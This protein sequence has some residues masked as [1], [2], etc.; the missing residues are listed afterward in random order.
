MRLVHRDRHLRLRL[1][2]RA[3]RSTPCTGSSHSSSP[4]GA[5]A[6]RF[7]SASSGVLPGAVGVDADADLR[8]DRGAHGGQ[9]A[10]VVADPDLDLHAAEPVARG[11][12]RGRGGARAV[13]GADRRVDRHRA[14]RARVDQPAPA[15]SACG[16]RRGPRAPGRSR[17]APGGDRAR[18][19]RRRARRRS[20]RCSPSTSRVGVQRRAHA[21][22]SRRR[23]RAPAAPPRPRPTSP[24]GKSS[25]TTSTSR[26]RSSPHDA[27][28]GARSANRSVRTLS[29]DH[30]RQ[31]QP[32][33]Q[34]DA[35]HELQHARCGRA[36]R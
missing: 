31:Q 6:R 36:R 21:A 1:R 7:A 12:G 28:S 9:P 35:E 17:P 33:R 2:P 3:A 10:G 5:S 19:G 14:D 16:A 8:P 15:A 32:R 29:A 11:G 26:S 27:R 20:A 18:R 23:R 34:E 30:S 22:P 25:R 13:L 24:S 4:T